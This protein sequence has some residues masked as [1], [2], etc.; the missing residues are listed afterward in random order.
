M[1]IGSI[2]S[3]KL[4]IKILT[5]NRVSIT[6]NTEDRFNGE[7]IQPG[8][9][10]LRT[11]AEHGLAM[12]IQFSD[13]DGSHTFL[14]DTGGA[15]ETVIENSKALK[16]D[17]TEVEKI[18]ISHGHFDHFGGLKE[19]ISLLK[20]GAEIILNPIGFI[21][22][23]NI[24]TKSG[25]EVPAE[26]LPDALKTLRKEGDLISNRKLPGF[27]RDFYQNLAN[28]HNVKIIETSEPV[29]LYKGIVTSGEIEL[30]DNNE[31]SKGFYL[32]KGRKDFQKHTFRDETSIYINIDDKGLV[33]LTGCG[34]VGLQNTVKHAQKLTGIKQV[35]AIIGG[36]HQESKTDN[37]L[38]DIVK[39][40]EELNP[41]ITC[42]MHCTGFNFN[43]LM[44]R[45]S[46]HTEGI[47]GT[48]FHL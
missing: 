5:A 23:Q 8:A 17:L 42:G 9:K 48:E 11:T 21:Q 18:I 4:T 29:K 16:V 7:V 32:V 3:G 34:H 1:E 44:S 45:H 27:N 38:E 22:N 43:K 12:S 36:L 46:S 41:K 15:M 26:E 33:V 30:F 40:V 28:E 39:Y 35:H 14:L 19:V 6:L 10:V 2:G 20:E 31:V 47:V 13:D 24:K 37:E 25:K